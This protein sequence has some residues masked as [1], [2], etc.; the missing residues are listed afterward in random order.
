MPAIEIY[1][2]SICGITSETHKHWG[3]ICKR[4]GQRVCAQ[5]C[6]KCEHHVSWSGI[7]F[8]RFK[9]AED[10]QREIRRRIQARF[11]E[12]SLKISQ[13]YYRRKREEAKLRAIKRAK[14]NA[15]KK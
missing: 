7:W 1:T 9:E 14:A 11:E 2:C 4:T 10:K 13:D 6:R 5:C 12:E 15:K 3:P 8:C